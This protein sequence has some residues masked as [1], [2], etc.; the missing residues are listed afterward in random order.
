MDQQTAF[1]TLKMQ[2][3]LAWLAYLRNFEETGRANGLSLQVIFHHAAPL[4]KHQRSLDWAEVAIRAAELDSN[5]GSDTEREE[6]LLSAMT[7][8][9]WFISQMGSR[10]GHFVLDKETV[11][12]WAMAALTLSICEV[13]DRAMSFWENLKRAKESSNSDALQQTAKDAHQLR[14]IKH[15]LNI[16]K[17][18]VDCGEL[19]SDS[20]LGEWLQLRESLP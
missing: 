13:K 18:L 8:R 12:Q 7:L 17:V 5:S 1:N 15:R 14:W 4:A 20:V 2:G 6:S 9:S 16:I 19:P 10:P 3:P 11:I